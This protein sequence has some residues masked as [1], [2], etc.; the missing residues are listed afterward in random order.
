M[1][2]AGEARSNAPSEDGR[3]REVS[4][5]P[6]PVRID[7]APRAMVAFLL[8]AAGL[9]LLIRLWPVLLA[10]VAALVVAGTLSPA[11][12][13]LEE[14]RVARGLGIAIVF[15]VFFIFAV[16][17]AVLTIPALVTQ[18]T[19]LLEHEP[20]LRAQ[21]A[22]ATDEADAAALRARIVDLGQRIALRLEKLHSARRR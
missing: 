4:E 3:P 14:K 19:G 2:G 9:W 18:A 12:R 1:T 6:R 22:A 20:A 16:L 21:L 17:V 10:L 15:T 5:P 8:V 11:V 13:W 7:V